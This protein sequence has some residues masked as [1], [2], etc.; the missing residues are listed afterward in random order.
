M[1]AKQARRK[2]LAPG[3][4]WAALVGLALAALS[5][6]LL[7]LVLR[8]AQ[9]ITIHVD[10]QDIHLR[11]SHA[12]TVAHALAEA[13]VRAGPLDRV[14]PPITSTVASAQIISVVR[15][16]TD[17]ITRT[18]AIPFA[19][20][21]SSDP[22]RARGYRQITRAGV[23]GSREISETITTEDGVET[24]RR[25]SAERVL[26]EPISE[27]MVVGA[28]EDPAL[29]AFRDSALGYLGRGGV[30]RLSPSVVEQT[31]FELA[32]L[33]G[34][35]YGSVRVLTRNGRP[36]L[37]LDTFARTPDDAT[38]FVFWWADELHAF[39]QVLSEGPYWMDGRAQTAAAGLELGIIVS[40]GQSGQA[41]APQY[42]L[43]QLPSTPEQSDTWQ[44]L[45][46]SQGVAAWLS[47]QGAVTFGSDGLD[48]IEVHGLSTLN[49][50]A[51]AIIE[52]QGCARRRFASVWQRT[53]NTYV[54]I[55]QG[56]VASPYASLWSFVDNLHSGNITATLP[57]AS[58]PQVISD[59]LKGGLGRPDLQWTT[60]G[61]EMDA[62]FDL[63]SK[64]ASLR[65]TLAQRGQDWLITNV[66][67]VPGQGKILF[68]GTRPV[69]RGLFVMNAAAGSPP[70]ALGNGQRYAWSPDYTHVAYDWQEQV[71]IADG[72]G[73]NVRSIG[74]GLA[75]AWSGDGKRLAF[76]RP[77][78]KGSLI[79][80]YSLDDGSETTLIGGSRPAWAPGTGAGSQRLA[81][82]SSAGAAALPG[83]YL[84]DVAAGAPILLASDGSEPLWSPDGAA[85][86]FLTSRQEIAVVTL[87]PSRVST[88]AKG[89][90]Y[91]WSA[92]GK[93]L[94]YLSAQAAGKPMVWN[95]ET[96]ESK[97]LLDRDDVDGLSWSPDG[98]EI[99][100][101]L[102]N[103]GG[104][105]QV[106]SDGSNLRRLGD[107]RD[108]I[109]GWPPR[110]GR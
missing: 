101:S 42:L 39:G 52:C 32:R 30:T 74:P 72:D 37:V 80:L 33:R 25:V 95:R 98:A 57:L 92:D 44:L 76:E 14:S 110:A 100:I 3:L 90:G 22:L 45:W 21:T 77:A 86:A 27:T 54:P 99:V 56:V 4:R 5:I 10:G 58:S 2:R 47:S 94:A 50:A 1:Q 15:V 67:P 71:Y 102:A 91:S 63:K 105:W 73:S 26:T 68:T 51:A 18:I 35:R 29:D 34:D 9:Q 97:T 87:A 7:A 82:A 19:R 84:I 66:G 36:W 69:V 88:V 46:S 96:E 40:P 31:L 75:P 103:A 55:A 93:G 106:N 62:S 108:P 38:L 65:V 85:V 59:A 11:L 89:W 24:Q 6:A 48:R 17:T 28:R 8:P 23:A 60:S 53:D 109:W 81:F 79:M 20:I 12:T 43:Y 13:G 61:R 41:L 107:G 64:V 83:V 70:L 104:M 16:Q 78:A 49:N